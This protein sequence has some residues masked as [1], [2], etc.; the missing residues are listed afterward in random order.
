MRLSQ[1][2]EVG[3]KARY[4]RDPRPKEGKMAGKKKKRG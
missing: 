1:G 3:G 2:G 4:G